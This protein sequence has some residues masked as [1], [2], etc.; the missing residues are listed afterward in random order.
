MFEQHQ[1]WECYYLFG[2][3]FHIFGITA[4]K[5]NCWGL[6]ELPPVLSQGP[7]KKSGTSW[8]QCPASCLASCLLSRPP[9]FLIYLVVPW[10]GIVSTMEKTFHHQVSKLLG[11][12]GEWAGCFVPGSAWVPE[13]HNDPKV[14]ASFIPK[15]RRPSLIPVKFQGPSFEIDAVFNRKWAVTCYSFFF[16]SKMMPFRAYG[17]YLL[18]DQQLNRILIT[19]ATLSR[20]L[21]FWANLIRAV[22]PT[23][24]N[25]AVEKPMF[26]F[27]L[28][29]ELAGIL[30]S[31]KSNL[32]HVK[33]L[34]RMCQAARLHTWLRNKKLKFL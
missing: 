6:W 11:S 24:P 15:A 1:S 26:P 27:L 10:L 23:L 33:W 31:E 20:T 21:P 29:G 14:D 32:I 9:G 3:Q 34:H 30:I 2:F 12:S 17:I 22:V 18:A 28:F 5:W 25:F 7:V 13:N 19:P 8:T 4:Y 16:F